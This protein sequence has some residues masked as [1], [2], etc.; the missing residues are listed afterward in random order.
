MLRSPSSRRLVIAAAGVALSFFACSQDDGGDPDVDAIAWVSPTSTSDV[1]VGETIELTVKVNDTR[2][3]AVVFTDDGRA[4]ATCDGAG[5]TADCRRGDLF[6][7]TTSFDRP[8]H[9]RLVATYSASGEE[10]SASLELDVAAAAGAPVTQGADAAAPDVPAPGG[11]KDG[12]T[13]TKPTAPANRGFLDPDRALH[14]VFGGVSWAVKGQAVQVVAAPK[15]DVAAIAACMKKY[16]ASI[17]KHADAFKVSRGSVVA[18]AMTESSCTNP[19]GS[20]DGLSSGPMQVTGSTCAAVAGGGISSA[21]CKTK[22]FT[23]PDF[24]F[25]IGA[26]YMGSSYQL[27]QHGNDPPKIAAAYNAG[28][29]RQS[30][31]NR[32]H[33]VVTGTHIER[34]V[35]AYNAYRAWESTTTTQQL[36]LDQEI[37]ARP[38]SFFSGE[39]VARAEDLPAQAAAGQV[40][41]VGDWAARDGGF[42]T[43]RDGRWEADLVIEKP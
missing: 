16:G 27:K 37:A 12:G 38:E 7:W 21:A 22:M 19:A 20:S 39:H 17:K 5:A 30:S 32:W 3:S 26:K 10:H 14:S 24:S 35:A 9:H 40:Y 31:A 6:R 43:F 23:S 15:G 28:S 2:A 33:M 4:V 29:I 1:S 11:E 36:A 42:V 18:T 13:T 34:F 25:Q 8:G 41:F